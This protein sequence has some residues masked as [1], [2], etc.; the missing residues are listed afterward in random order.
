MA[1]G[2]AFPSPSWPT[3]RARAAESWYPVQPVFTWGVYEDKPDLP[4]V[5]FRG[6]IAGH[7]HD[8]LSAFAAAP[9][10]WARGPYGDSRLPDRTRRD[11]RRPADRRHVTGR[12]AHVPPAV[13][14]RPGHRPDRVGGPLRCR[15]Q[16]SHALRRRGDLPV[17]ISTSCNEFAGCVHAVGC[18]GGGASPLLP[19]QRTRKSSLGATIAAA[20]PALP[21][22][23]GGEFFCMGAPRNHQRPG[24][25][26]HG[27]A[28]ATPPIPPTTSSFISATTIWASPHS[29]CFVIEC[30]RP[31][32]GTRT[33]TSGKATFLP[34]PGT[35]FLPRLIWS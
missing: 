3:S 20:A 35:T 4:E 22:P 32:H 11:A 9:A 5:A 1:T 2:R 18:R 16:G 28:R 29:M 27:F 12:A 15:L 31:P 23:C 10:R 34:T 21:I 30:S 26:R 13:V 6:L 7:R 25:D 8:L 17:E 33:S 14:D 19:P 24:V